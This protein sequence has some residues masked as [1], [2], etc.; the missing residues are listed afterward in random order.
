MAQK[1]SKN[2]LGLAAEYSVAGE[3]CRRNLYA[4][5]IESQAQQYRYV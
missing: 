2:T 1:I 3:L 4:G 5:L